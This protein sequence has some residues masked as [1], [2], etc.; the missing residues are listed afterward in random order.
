VILQE[1]V[2]YYD[3]AGDLAPEGWEWKRIPYLIEIR[4]DGSFI[5]L[6]SLR[7]GPK[8]TDVKPSLVPKSE[9]RQGTKA[10][11]KPNLLWDHHGFV[12]AH[13]KSHDSKDVLAAQRQHEHFIRRVEA[14]I[15]SGTDDLGLQAVSRFLASDARTKV[16]EDPLWSECVKVAGCNLTFRLAGDDVLVVQR[17]AVRAAIAC[18]SQKEPN[19]APDASSRALCLVTGELATI[20]ALH[21]PIAGVCE[22]P[23]PMAAVND[24]VSPAY[25]SFGKS[26]GFNFPVGETAV[27]KYTTALNRLLQPGSRQ[28]LKI[29]DMAT[30][31]WSQ[32][33]EG[34][35][36]ENSFAALFDEVVDDPNAH[37]DKVRALY[38]STQSGRF[39]GAAGE[40]RFFV[41][42]LAPNSA[43]VV[44]RFWHAKPLHDI[45]RQLKCWFDDIK[46]EH[47]SYEPEHLPVRRLLES[48]C[49]PTKKR[50]YGD[51][52]KLP[53]AIAGDLMRAILNNGEIPALLLNG[54]IQRCRAEQARKDDK[55]KPVR[56]VS[57]ARAALMR[58]AVNRYR[59]F[60]QPQLRN[61]SM[62]LDRDLAD[63]PYALGRLFAVYERTQEAAADRD[64]NR[65][66][67]DA[68]FGAAMATPASVFPRLMRLNQIHLRDVKR[69]QPGYGVYLD[70]LILAINDK[71]NPSRNY[72]RVLALQEQAQF[73]LGYYHQRQ[74]FFTKADANKTGAAANAEAR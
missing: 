16:R 62:S 66:I 57:Y 73:A 36:V 6:T 24:G 39:D 56:N 44:V 68:F 69:S 15:A 19:F 9:N 59:R 11:E 58:A 52:E 1:L 63:P 30:I 50:P 22:K 70:K 74:D 12:L 2:R 60:H 45:A 42:G 27:F 10:Y 51:I 46:I 23:S 72:P 38:S 8:S 47:A 65:T 61:I 25:S 35:D 4:E 53:P 3:R 71:I 7:S 48:A 17:D 18:A 32:S 29:G 33:I 54:V 40:D 5:Q 13:P 43:R 21:F 28:Q 37:T 26:Q 20:Q 64:L 31:F 14:L 67:R 55:G 49:L 41:L 34:A